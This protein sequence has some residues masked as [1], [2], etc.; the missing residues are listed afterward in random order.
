MAQGLDA[1]QRL[2]RRV[3]LVR[4]TPRSDSE[5]S[6]ATVCAARKPR[7][8]P[9]SGAGLHMVIGNAILQ[10]DPVPGGRLSSDAE[11]VSIPQH[12]SH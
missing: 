3:L 10:V 1:A 2:T 7:G 5:L 8:P 12:P 11:P 6:N 4:R 9:P